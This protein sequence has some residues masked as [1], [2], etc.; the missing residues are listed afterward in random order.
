[1]ENEPNESLSEKSNTRRDFL[2]YS[3]LLGSAALLSG[4]VLARAANGLPATGNPPESAPQGSGTIG[5]ARPV[6]PEFK[7]EE[8]G[9]ALAVLFKTY[10]HTIPYQHKFNDALI[11]AWLTSFDF[12]V[13]QGKQKEF[14]DHY[15]QTMKPILQ[16]G[17]A[18]VAKSGP[19]AALAFMFEKT[20][21]SVQLFEEIT[22]K[23][24][25]RSFPCPYK[26]IL[27]MCRPLKMFSI[28]WK[29]V[30]SNFCTP[31]YTGFGKE[32]GVE[33]KMTPGEICSARI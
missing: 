15:I 26:A 24:G 25:E 31:V 3:S 7:P 18:K 29:D 13:A 19:E 5:A 6:L 9:K 22:I 30:C 12:A 11:K 27:D 8:I 16:F 14:A 28:E 2:K 4:P 20:M 23:P 10:A 33:I 21:C 32:M 17:K 1:M